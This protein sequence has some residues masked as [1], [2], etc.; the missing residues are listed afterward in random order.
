MSIASAHVVEATLPRAS[1]FARR[2]GGR[3]LWTGVVLAGVIVAVGF[4]SPLLASDQPIVCRHDGRVHFPAVVDT[5]QKVPL[6]GRVLR[7]SEPFRFPGFDAK[8]ALAPDAFAIWPVV[9]FGPGEMTDDLS[10]APSREHWLGTDE[11]GRDV[12]ARLVHGAAVSVRVGLLA[13]LL[14]GAIGITVGAAAGYTGGWTDRVLSRVI[15]VVICFPAFFLILAVMMWLEPSVAGVIVVI[16]L[17][18]W[19]GVARFARAEFLRLKSADFVLAA[20]CAGN[21][22]LRIAVRHMLPCTL[23]PVL[24]TLTF[25]VAD[26]VMIEAGL[27]WLGFGVP[28]TQPSWG[29]L[30]R[31]GYDQLLS[32]PHLIYPP[33]I[34]IFATVLACHLIG[35]GWRRRLDPKAE[36]VSG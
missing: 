28:P 19:T 27:S 16:A 25:G 30:L 10:A 31:S 14:A 13:T 12:F 8:H 3:R 32:A 24:V 11:Q 20:R 23:A 1:V 21:S 6:L 26:A 29:H 5:L 35:E 7:K 33:C 18:R 22:P 36:M 2:R 9:A 17:T 4:F 34:A 15:E